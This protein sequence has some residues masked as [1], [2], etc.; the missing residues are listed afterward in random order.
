MLSVIITWAVLNLALI[1]VGYDPDNSP[2]G[3]AWDPYPF[4][5]LNL[6]LSMVAAI[7]APII[8]MSQNR[9]A[10]LDKLQNDYVRCENGEIYFISSL[11]L[12]MSLCLLSLSVPLFFE[13]NIKPAT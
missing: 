9:Q 13:E 7:Q 6:F 10:F 11:L 1:H 2:N 3:K 12:N 5:L 4:I 8:M